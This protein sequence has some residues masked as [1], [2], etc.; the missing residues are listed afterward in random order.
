[1]FFYAWKSN[2]T[3][4]TFSFFT[5]YRI[6]LYC[7]KIC[8]KI[9]RGTENSS[10]VA[11]IFNHTDSSLKTLVLASILYKQLTSMAKWYIIYHTFYNINII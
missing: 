7:V 2:N 6:V 1:M 10:T 11:D 5:Y 3:V 8:L 4:H 9:V